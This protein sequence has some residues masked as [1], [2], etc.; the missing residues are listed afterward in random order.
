MPLARIEDLFE[1]GVALVILFGTP[2]ILILTYHQRKMAE[3]LQ[4]N[5]SQQGNNELQQQVTLLQM[6][7]TELRTVVQ[8]HIINNDPSPLTSAPSVEQRLNQ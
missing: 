4:R 1:A 5:H 8:E 7:M 6:Q 2:A 3:I